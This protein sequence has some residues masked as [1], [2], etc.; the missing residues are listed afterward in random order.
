M[1]SQA[2]PQNPPTTVLPPLLILPLELKLQILSNFSDHDSDPSHALTLMVLRRTHKILRRI[3]PN[4]S[5]VIPP[6]AERF[7]AAEGQYPYLFPHEC[8][9]S[10]SLVF[11]YPCYDCIG[12]I[13]RRKSRNYKVA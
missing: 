3:T 9:P 13:S 6:T 1:A 10:R 12:L 11:L 8:T 4:P 2:A 7:L 5:R